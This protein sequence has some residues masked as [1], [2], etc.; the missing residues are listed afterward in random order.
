VNHSN[1]AYI[2]EAYP[3]PKISSILPKLR[4]IL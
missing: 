2:Y 4:T 3:N 1:K